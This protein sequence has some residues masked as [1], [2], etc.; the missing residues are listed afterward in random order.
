MTKKIIKLINNERLNAK[1]TSVK[2]TGCPGAAVDT[3][4]SIDYS[5]SYCTSYA[6]DLC[7]KDYTACREGA[8][9]IC[10]NIDN[11]GPCE[12]VGVNDYCDYND[13]AYNPEVAG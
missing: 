12:G 6:Y 4:T 11:D 1:I 3:C 10:G 13:Y 8:Q 5:N 9:D 2:A 7:N